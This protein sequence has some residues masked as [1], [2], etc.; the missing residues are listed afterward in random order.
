MDHLATRL[1]LKWF[2][3]F[4]DHMFFWI[5]LNLVAFGLCLTVVGI[6]FAL[7]GLVAVGAVIADGKEASWRDFWQ[8]AKKHA[9]RMAFWV[10][11]I[12]LALISGLIAAQQYPVWLG[13]PGYFLAGLVLWLMV[14]FLAISFYLPGAFVHRSELSLK[15]FYVQGFYLFLRHPIF[16]LYWLC[17]TSAFLVISRL[18]FALF[19]PLFTLSL[20]AVGLCAGY[21]IAMREFTLEPLNP[22]ILEEGNDNNKPKKPTSWKEIQ[23]AGSVISPSTQQLEEEKEKHKPKLEYDIPND[24]LKRSFRE[25]FRPWEYEQ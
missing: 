1:L 6:P 10:V 19:L 3:D 5:L 13:K 22:E 12:L 4:W 25:L 2:W 21:T 7:G 24:E 20:L 11:S 8:G 15:S 16:S 18:G 17:L 9:A 23:D 14:G